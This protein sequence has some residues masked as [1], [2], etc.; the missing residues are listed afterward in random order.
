[1]QYLK[2]GTE[3]DIFDVNQELYESIHR[4]STHLVV[5]GINAR[6]QIELNTYGALVISMVIMCIA[7]AEEVN[8]CFRD[9]YSF[10]QREAVLIVTVTHPCLRD[11]Q[12][13]YFR[14]IFWQELQL[15]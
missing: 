1:M 10:A 9:L 6:D 4:K 3:V 13:S 5:Q 2:E 12:F 11:E 7:G 15:P 8:A 14:R